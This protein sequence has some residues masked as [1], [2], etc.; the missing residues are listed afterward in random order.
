MARELAQELGEKVRTSY[1]TFIGDQEV[2]PVEPSQEPA[3]EPSA[4]RKRSRSRSGLRRSHP[5]G[6]GSS[7]AV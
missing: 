2:L 4:A 5:P 1:R 3:P 6:A 7:Q